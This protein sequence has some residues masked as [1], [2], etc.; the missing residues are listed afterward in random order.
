[1]RIDVGVSTPEMLYKRTLPPFV[2]V[3]LPTASFAQG[4][5]D[6]F[7]SLKELGFDPTYL[8]GAVG[9]GVL[10]IAF[11]LFAII[12][13]KIQKNK[14]P[15]MM[16][17][18]SYLDVTGLA[19]Q[20]LLTPEEQAKVRQAM[21]RQL[22]RQQQASSRPQLPGELGL[23]ADPEVQRLEALAQARQRGEATETAAMPTPAKPSTTMKPEL[24]HP[25]RPIPDQPP[26]IP[27]FIDPIPADWGAPSTQEDVVLP[28]DVLAMAE[29]GLI[30]PEELEAIKQR[31]RAK[32]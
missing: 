27:V 32:K 11:Y 28:P 26:E 17:G 12:Y 29:S 22:N 2:L 19:K 30:T 25:A 10:L 23:L 5:S 16:A 20:G 24:Q 15:D 4:F 31:M 14:S 21:S 7:G 1:M 8:I 18:I 3:L 6:T 13:R 9:L